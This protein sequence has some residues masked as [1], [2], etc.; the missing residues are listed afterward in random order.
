[1]PNVKEITEEILSGKGF[2]VLPGV[3]SPVDAAAARASAIAD[4]SSAG[5]GG[6]SARNEEIKHGT[7][8]AL[9]HQGEVFERLVQ[10]P[11]I[12]QIAEALLGDD[13]TLSSYSCRIMWPGATEMGV[14]VDYPYWAMP[15][16]FAVQPPLMLQV[17]WM[18]QDFTETN[19][20]TLVAPA[21]Q[22]LARR[23]DRERFKREAIKVTGVS[24]TAIVSHG[25]LW[26]DTSPNHTD[27]PRVSL[28]INY[29]N[30]VIRPLDSRIGEV[31]PEV[32]ARAT[33]KLRQ[34]LG[35]EFGQ[36][37]GRDLKRQRLY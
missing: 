8:R 29:G 11:A 19:G 25:L 20:A 24:G 37:L 4:A 12:I 18:L 2:F 28:L 23:P 22:L 16:P 21:S 35:L 33:P 13:M 7:T 34:L 36:A 10:N 14:H 1:M 17:I 32:L 31:P 15:E 26:H 27:E 3:M 9:L 5:L 6:N 30:K